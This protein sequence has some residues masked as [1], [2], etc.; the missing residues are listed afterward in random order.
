MNRSQGISDFESP[1]NIKSLQRFLGTLN[2]DPM[3]IKNITESLEP[4]YNLLKKDEKFNWKE[5]HS[6]TFKNI[7]MNWEGKWSY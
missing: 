5:K 1:N 6:V 3:F 7:K 4:L 2:Y